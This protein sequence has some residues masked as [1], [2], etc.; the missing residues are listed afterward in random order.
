VR[1]ARQSRVQPGIDALIR[2]RI[3]DLSAE[4][5]GSLSDITAAQLQ[6][7]ALRLGERDLL[8]LNDEE[9]DFGESTNP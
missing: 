2:A 4:I 7:L 9:A 1:A 5:A 6:R 3:E 8:D